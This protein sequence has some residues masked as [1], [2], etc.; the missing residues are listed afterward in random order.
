[1]EA[2]HRHFRRLL[3]VQDE[4]GVRMLFRFYDPRVLRVYLP[5]C[6]PGE[7]EQVFGPVE[8]FLTEADEPDRI[9]EFRHQRGTLAQGE[10]HVEKRLAWLGDYLRK[11]RDDEPAK[12]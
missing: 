8:F 4:R 2:L 6:R 10:V 1:M 3:R 5:T 7:L 12:P 11:H 9:L